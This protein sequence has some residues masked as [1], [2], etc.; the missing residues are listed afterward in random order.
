MALWVDTLIDA[1]VF[2]E[3]VVNVGQREGFARVAHLLCE[4]GRR[5]ELAGIAKS[6]EYTLPMTQEQL[7][8]STGMSVVHINRVLKRL[9]DEKLIKRTKRS[10]HIPNWEKLR[11]VAGFSELYLHLDQVARGHRADRSL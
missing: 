7:A 10:V 9:S 11:S 6:H 2:R 1:S 3:W 8:D 5:L 4:F